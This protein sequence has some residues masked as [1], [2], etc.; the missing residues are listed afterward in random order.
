LCLLKGEKGSIDCLPIQYSCDN[1]EFMQ[2]RM[3]EHKYIK[4]FRYLAHLLMTISN[5]N[6]F[7]DLNLCHQL[8]CEYKMCE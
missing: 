2:L 4:N 8:L 1:K 3:N 6:Y 5:K 7:W